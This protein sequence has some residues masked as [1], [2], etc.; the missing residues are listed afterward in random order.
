MGT[1]T[2]VVTSGVRRASFIPCHAIQLP[3]CRHRINSG[4]FA[5]LLC[6]ATGGVDCGI[7]PRAQFSPAR[8]KRNYINQNAA[9]AT[10]LSNTRTTCD[11][12]KLSA[13][14]L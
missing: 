6:G 12:R 11:S 3:C 7:L 5:F 9:T 4:S 2:K 8:M 13:E 1:M 10:M 14:Q